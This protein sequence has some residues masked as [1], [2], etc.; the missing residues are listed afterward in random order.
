MVKKFLDGN[1]WTNGG[2]VK[3]A[4]LKT[5]LLKAHVFADDY[6]FRSWMIT[7]VSFGLL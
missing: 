7:T 1:A 5:M 6:I 2:V 4:V 3:Q